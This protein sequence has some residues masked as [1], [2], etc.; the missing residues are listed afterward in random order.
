MDDLINRPLYLD[1]VR[2]F[3][4]RDLIKVFVGQRRVGKSCLLELVAR[5]LQTSKQAPNVIRINLELPEFSEL[6]SESDLQSYISAKKKPGRN[7]LLIDEVQEI[8][9][10]ERVLRSFNASGDFDIYCTGSNASL[11]SRDL[12][13]LLAGRCIEIPVFTL[14][15]PE[16][17]I[18]HRCQDSDESLRHYLQ[19]GGLPYLR[20]L[21]QEAGVLTEYLRNIYQAI[22][23][24]DVVSRH[25]LRNSRLLEQVVHFLADV[26]G[27][28]VTARRISDFLKSQQ[29]KTSPKVIL[30]YLDHLQEACFIDKVQRYN[31]RGRRLFEVNDKFY[32]GDLGLRNAIT[33][34]RPGDIGQLLENT[35]YHH[36]RARG[37]QVR[38]GY[39]GGR[40]IDFIAE[41]KGSLRYYQVAYLLSD[42]ATV[43]REFG[44]LAKI[45]DDYPKFVISLDPM[46]GGERQ[47]IQHLSLREFL[48]NDA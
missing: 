25:N 43:E 23:Y 32:F 16:Y 11:L 27:S 17:L 42:K 1:R 48:L 28:P 29:I 34:Y 4:E 46:A 19:F 12:S 36:L 9:G 38:I 8:E 18:F 22:L 15:Y 14:T 24:R 47:G 44:N 20:H 33:G 3:M 35:V 39:L 37:F 26:M 5:E 40:E 13:T 10:F 41:K 31:I 2:P 21:D 45:P 7:L 30:E 6:R